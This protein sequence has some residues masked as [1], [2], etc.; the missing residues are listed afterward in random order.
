M[1]ELRNSLIHNRNYCHTIT[2]ELHKRKLCLRHGVTYMY[3]FS[4]TIGFY[5]NELSKYFSIHLIVYSFLI[6]QK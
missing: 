1:A 5:D 6:F 2:G 4:F 3:E